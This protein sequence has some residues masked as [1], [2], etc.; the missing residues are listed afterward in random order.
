MTMLFRFGILGCFSF[1]LFVPSPFT[2]L[3]PNPFPSLFLFTQPDSVPDV[4]SRG[5]DFTAVW[6]VPNGAD[7]HVGVRVRVGRQQ[8]GAR[9]RQYANPR[10]CKKSELSSTVVRETC[11]ACFLYARVP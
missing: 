6:L 7:E 9:Y 4:R 2:G 10:A 8:G 3:N 11:K 1:P 5:L